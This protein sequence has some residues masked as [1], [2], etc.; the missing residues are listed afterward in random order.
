MNYNR[1]TIDNYLIVTRSSENNIYILV[2]DN[3][4]NN[5]YNITIDENYNSSANTN[6]ENNVTL[7]LNSSLYH[8]IVNCIEKRSFYNMSII[9]KKDIE[10][11]I[12]LTLNCTFEYDKFEFSYE[13]TLF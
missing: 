2:K 4:N 13:I 10:D 1:T 12:T 6:S 7:S 9:S 3:N 8:F 11:E 5:E